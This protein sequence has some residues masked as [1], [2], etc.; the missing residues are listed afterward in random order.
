[1]EKEHIKMYL[2]AITTLI[3]IVGLVVILNIPDGECRETEDDSGSSKLTGAVTGFATKTKA[4]G[5]SNRVCSDKYDVCKVQFSTRSSTILSSDGIG[6]IKTNDGTY[7]I[8]VGQPDNSNPSGDM[9]LTWTSEYG[10]TL[11]LDGERHYSD[12]MWVKFGPLI[13]PSEL[14]GVGTYID[15]IAD[16]TTTFHLNK[17]DYDKGK[18]VL[19]KH[20]KKN[21]FGGIYQTLVDAHFIPTILNN[22]PDTWW[23]VLHPTSEDLGRIDKYR[24]HLRSLNTNKAKYALNQLNRLFPDST[25]VFDKN[26]NPTDITLGWLRSDDPSKWNVDLNPTDRSGID[27][28]T[29]RELQQDLDELMGEMEE[30]TL[31]ELEQELSPEEDSTEKN[32]PW[33]KFWC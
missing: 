10:E 30:E 27:A 26:G 11:R 15:R 16:R 13:S 31:A 14:P 33:W 32:C 6:K 29:D 18:I 25:P 19:H 5:N 17:M 22:N 23:L 21:F 2:R 8:V 24:N 9:T 4:S 20:T 12:H 7:E 1:M 28:M 3:V